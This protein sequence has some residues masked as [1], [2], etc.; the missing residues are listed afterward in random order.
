MEKVVT[1]DK[2]APNSSVN[3]D[4][5]Q[6]QVLVWQLNLPATDCSVTRDL[7]CRILDDV[8]GS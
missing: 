5:S 6:A 3:N 8:F 4:L 2:I 7:V 1:I